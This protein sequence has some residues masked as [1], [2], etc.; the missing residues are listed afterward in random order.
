VQLQE[1]ATTRAFTSSYELT[2]RTVS[3]LEARRVQVSPEMLRRFASH[4]DSITHAAEASLR[5][6]RRI[7]DLDPSSERIAQQ[8]ME[9]QLLRDGLSWLTQQR[10]QLLR[11][12]P[13]IQGVWTDAIHRGIQALLEGH[14]DLLREIDEGTFARR[15][16]VEVI[17]SRVRYLTSTF[18]RSVA[19]GMPPPVEEPPEELMEFIAR[20]GLAEDL[21][22]A[23]Q[24]V[25]EA[26]PEGRN[27][28]LR[29]THDPEGHE[30]WVSIG[31]SVP[32]DR[33]LER[34]LTYHVA[35]R[36]VVP[37][38]QANKLRLLY[39]VV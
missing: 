26:F 28:R 31:V 38:A 6:G 35:L 33:T 22:C 37:A 29:L 18:P 7:L 24:T 3:D 5:L 14:D 9:T 34:F 39:Q 8:R 12:A 10:P 4:L 36:R 13:K 25:R 17:A 16:P 2:R 21:L 19:M 32:D 11:R 23:V 27:L 15:T 20:E 1:S 30:Q